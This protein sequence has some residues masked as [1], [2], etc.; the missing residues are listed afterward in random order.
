MINGNLNKVLKLLFFILTIYTMLALYPLAITTGGP[1]NA[2]VV[3]LGGGFFLL[4][5][6]LLTL[7][8]VLN[9]SRT[10]KLS[11]RSARNKI[12]SVTALIVWGFLTIAFSIDDPA[13]TLIYLTPYLITLITL[14]LFSFRKHSRTKISGPI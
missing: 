8:V 14:A 7:P 10:D 1:C 13:P 12:L 3:L 11:I 4:S 6:F 9:I 2:G 5:C